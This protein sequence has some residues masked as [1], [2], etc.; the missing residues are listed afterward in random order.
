MTSD[1]SPS[2][3]FGAFVSL[4]VVLALLLDLWLLPQLLRLA[5]GKQLPALKRE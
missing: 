5:F 2:A 1:F 4:A 3:E